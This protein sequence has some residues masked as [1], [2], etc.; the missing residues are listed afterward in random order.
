MPVNLSGFKSPKSKWRSNRKASNML[1]N[2]DLI[3]KYEHLDRKI[4]FEAKLTV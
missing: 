4:K 1:V 3:I 2:S